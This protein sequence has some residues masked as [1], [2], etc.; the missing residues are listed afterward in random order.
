M[1]D[2]LDLQNG[3]LSAISDRMSPEQIQNIIKSQNLNPVNE[4]KPGVWKC[5]DGE[6]HFFVFKLVDS[7]SEIKIY[8]S[9]LSSLTSYQ[10]KFKRLIL[11]R[12]VATDGA[13]WILIPF[14]SGAGYHDAWKELESGKIGGAALGNDLAQEMA[15]VIIDLSKINIEDIQRNDSFKDISNATFNFDG[16][17]K[18]FEQRS[19]TLVSH[20]LI[21]E[22]EV[23]KAR[24]IL[25]TGF[26]SSKMIFSCG[27]YYPRNIIKTDDGKIVLIDWQGWGEDYRVNFID[28]QEGLI[29][30]A[31]IH[32]WNN[33]LWQW[34]FLNALQKQIHIDPKDFQKA[35]IIKSFDQACLWPPISDDSERNFKLIQLFRFQMQIF[36][37]ALEFEYVQKLLDYTKP[38]FNVWSFLKK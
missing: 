35:L 13:S 11:P 24:A 20:G 36:S 12:L 18:L 19:A 7:V 9:I 8:Q 33:Y 28:H 32:M 2:I 27:D 14:Y 15:D 10:N 21:S 25:G 31:Y 16:W 23:S 3:I 4:I 34:K 29:A 26:T 1:Y 37:N 5:E 30:F 38:K 17:F 6:G 22:E